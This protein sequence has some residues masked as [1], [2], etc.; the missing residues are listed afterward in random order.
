MRTPI[1]FAAIFALA[2]PS[3]AEEPREGD[4]VPHE[5]ASIKRLEPDS[6]GRV[7]VIISSGTGSPNRVG[8]MPKL[9]WKLGVG[10]S[11]DS[12]GFNITDLDA[13]SGLAKMRMRKD[14]NDDDEPTLA[15]K[16]GDIIT[17]IN[18]VRI[19][20]TTLLV[21]AVNS[22]DNPRDMPIVLKDGDTGKSYLFF[23]TARKELK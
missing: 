8:K 13:A 20:S 1:A 18:N 7:P 19:T 4:E 22:A 23:V 16:K 11:I 12:E 21:F 17:H 15:A 9:R 3:Y 6:K 5:V 14:H 2:L 10:G